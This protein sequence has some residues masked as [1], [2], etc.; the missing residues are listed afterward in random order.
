MSITN[1]KAFEEAIEQGLIDRGE[2][3]KGDPAKFER[4]LALDRDI[5]F[6]FLKIT[7]KD[8]WD[9]LVGIHGAEV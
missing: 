8:T 1:E 4:V 2:Y 3:E 7:Q 9:A 6:R 5:L